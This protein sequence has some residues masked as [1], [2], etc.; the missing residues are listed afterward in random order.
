MGHGYD[1]WYNDKVIRYEEKKKIYIYIY[2]YSQKRDCMELRWFD[3]R[4]LH[5][6]T[7]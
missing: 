5:P 1:L 3:F 6:Q 2:I 7:Q 4:Y